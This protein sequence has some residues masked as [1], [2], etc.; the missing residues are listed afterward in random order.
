MRVKNSADTRNRDAIRAHLPHI[1]EMFGAG[2]FSA[3]MLVHD[4]SN[5]PG[6][7]AMSA[8]KDRIQYRYVETPRGGRVD[9]V[10]TDRD[11]L[12]AVHDFLRF[13]IADHETGDPATVRPR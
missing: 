11:A 6:T 12:A 9:I 5:V 3:P 13:Q 1:V 8:L 4:S 7:K 2:N 10:T